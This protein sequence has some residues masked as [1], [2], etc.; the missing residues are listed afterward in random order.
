[1][2]TQTNGQVR[3]SLASQLDRHEAALSRLEA[4]IDAL[5]DGLN[6]AVA[7]CVEQSVT[8]AVQAA[9]VEVLTNPALQQ[10]LRQCVKAD[11]PENTIVKGVKRLW[12]WLVSGVK[13][14]CTAVV[15]MARKAGSTAASVVTSCRET[16]AGKVAA[17]CH[18]MKAAITRTWTGTLLALRL[19][20]RLRTVLLAALAVGLVVAVASYWCGPM[21]SSVVNGVAGGC[22][23]LALSAM[24][25]L[26]GLVG[27]EQAQDT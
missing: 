22:T 20:G 9:V 23:W 26:R 11:K 13:I 5:A 24:R 7:T 21:V 3:K 1:M 6:Q 2:S 17:G 25:A 16:A 18:K 8:T 15:E 19:L 12:G 4:I 27:G 14:A 10:Q